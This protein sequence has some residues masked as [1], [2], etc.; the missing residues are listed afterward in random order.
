MQKG[1]EHTQNCSRGLLKYL[2]Y[3]EREEQSFR[4]GSEFNLSPGSGPRTR[5]ADW[6]P[7]SLIFTQI[8]IFSPAFSTIKA[9]C[10]PCTMKKMTIYSHLISPKTLIYRGLD[11]GSGPGGTL[12][13]D[14]HWGFGLDLDPY[15]WNECGSETLGKS[16]VRYYFRRRGKNG[17]QTYIP[18][19]YSSK[20]STWKRTRK[21]SD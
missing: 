9:R 14:P 12:D 6:D 8:Y 7:G 1:Q 16:T 10:P 13:P 4:F 20:P 19:R 2:V 15:I 17:F 18:Y 3:G 5:N 21:C 11:P